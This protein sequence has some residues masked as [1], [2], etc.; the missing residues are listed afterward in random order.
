ME[1]EHDIRLPHSGWRI[2]GLLLLLFAATLILVASDFLGVSPFFSEKKLPPVQWR[3][4]QTLS[5]L[6]LLAVEAVLIFM[7]V[8]RDRRRLRLEAML[9]ESEERVVFS[10]ESA[11]LGL[12]QWDAHSDRFWATTHCSEMLGIR[13][14][15]EYSMDMMTAAVHPDDLPTVMAT[16]TRGIETNS[17]FEV[18]YRLSFGEEETKWV[19]VRGRPTRGAHKRVVRIAGTI[20]DITQRMEMQAEIDKQR[21]SLTHLTRV[22]M[23]GE[24]SGALAHELNQPLTAILSNAQAMQRMIRHDSIDV[25]ELRSA[26]ADIIE[27]DSR[28]GDVIRHLRTLLKKDEARRDLIDIVALVERVLSLTRGDLT[29]RRIGVVTRFVTQNL[30][31]WG[32]AVQLQQLFLNLVLNAADAMDAA[33]PG[34]LTIASEIENAGTVHLSVSDTG[35]GIRH[36]MLEKLFEPF[37]ST[38]KHGLGLGLSISRAIV[39]SH[40]G[41]LSAENNIGPGSTFHV[42]LPLAIMEMS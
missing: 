5:V 10:A 26:I 38:K 29:A 19:R 22:G 30:K 35:A 36:E 23:I 13:P 1:T 37:F 16:V 34:V 25:A 17:L 14:G 31:V 32:D 20:V 33:Q 39:S 7:I 9:R 3:D 27:D 42:F 8:T 12:W 40:N 41:R 11:D 18:E 28:A 2:L 4:F 6:L 15:K 21:Q 24:L